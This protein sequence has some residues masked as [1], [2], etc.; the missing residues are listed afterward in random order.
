[1]YI[2]TGIDLDKQLSSLRS[3]GQ[4]IE[5][6]L[7]FAIKAFDLPM[8]ISLKISFYAN[9]EAGE[10][11]I[12]RIVS[13][14]ES[15]S[16]FDLETDRI[17][18]EEGI[19]WLRYKQS[20]MLDSIHRRMNGFLQNEFGIELHPYDLDFKFHTTLFMDNDSAKTEKAYS[21]LGN[22]NYPEKVRINRYILGVSPD[23][24]FNS[25]RIINTV[26]V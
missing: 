23:G 3:A 26:E 9:E 17:E 6:K 16:A 2:W 14:Y 12:K 22:P 15:L 8:H 13:F 10:K 24:S 19:V 5:G 4:V 11:I 25:Y 7:D 21:L 18:H 20:S 1:M